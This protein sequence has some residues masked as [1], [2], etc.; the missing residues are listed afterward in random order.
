MDRCIDF[1]IPGLDGGRRAMRRDGRGL[2]PRRLPLPEVSADNTRP[3]I[4]KTEVVCGSVDIVAERSTRRRP[5]Q[6]TFL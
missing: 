3:G 4:S 1:A 6:L 2:R 5:L